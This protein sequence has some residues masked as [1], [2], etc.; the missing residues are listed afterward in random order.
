M[1]SSYINSITHPKYQQFKKLYTQ[2]FPLFEQRTA[3]QQKNAF[4]DHRYH[5]K[6]YTQDADFIGF[7]A[8]W[9]F[10]PLTYIEHFA[11]NTSLRSKGYGS[12]VLT[13]FIAASVNQILLE[14]DPVVDPTSQARLKFYRNCGFHQNP[15][16]HTHPPYRTQFAA[17]PLVV[18]S[19]NG[20]ITEN[21]YR[22]FADLINNVVMNEASSNNFDVR[23]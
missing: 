6:I 1:D 14:I 3:N 12:R 7:I 22:K 20:Q 5:V 21:Q 13:D 15:Y 11:I 4:A 9:E 23:L 19:T 17:H 18:L 2:S 10:D 8:Y 16:N